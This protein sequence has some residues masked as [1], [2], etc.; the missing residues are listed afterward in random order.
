M[1][2][3]TLYPKSR[4][5]CPVKR[6]SDLCH[7]RYLLSCLQSTPILL[8]TCPCFW[9]LFLHHCRAV[10]I[11]DLS[12]APLPCHIANSRLAPDSFLLPSHPFPSFLP[13]YFCI[14]V[15]KANQ[16][17]SSGRIN[18]KYCHISHQSQY[19]DEHMFGIPAQPFLVSLS[20]PE[21]FWTVY[22]RLRLSF[23]SFL[24][25]FFFFFLAVPGH[26]EFLG[27]G[28]D[29]SCS[30]NLTHCASLGWLRLS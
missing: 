5:N 24:F 2:K 25:F 28:S 4:I 8:R 20:G 14:D 29:L 17:L 9:E 10:P 30:C 18:N 7:S 13:C 11:Q 12:I 21:G 19:K 3:I 16:F 23:L 22:H 26:M 27:Q 15:E 1:P 6:D